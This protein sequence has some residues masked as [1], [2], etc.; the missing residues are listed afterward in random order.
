MNAHGRRIDRG[1]AEELLD[2]VTACARGG[3]RA[4][5][6]GEEAADPLRRLLLAAAAGDDRVDPAGEEAAVRAFR[7]ATAARAAARASRRRVTVRSLLSVKVGVVLFVASV[8]VGWTAGAPGLPLID[9]GPAAP[10]TTVSAS[11]STSPRRDRDRPTPTTFRSPL[12]PR[13]VRLCRAYTAAAATDPRAAHDPR[14][15]PLAAQAGGPDRI[16]AFCAGAL[17]AASRGPVPSGASPSGGPPTAD[18]PSDHPGPASGRARGRPGSPTAR[19]HTPVLPSQAN[20]PPD[21]PGRPQGPPHSVGGA[22]AGDEDPPP[23]HDTATL[24]EEDPG[25]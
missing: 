13:T 3:P 9:D 23:V 5:D 21:R 18:S 16:A 25:P 7:E 8:G 19:P 6:A 20:R 17:E 12:P 4:D 1:S 15:A 2:A 14:F 22:A 10:V 11:A 24:P